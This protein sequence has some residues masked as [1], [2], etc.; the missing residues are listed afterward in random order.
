MTLIDT[1]S[2]IYLPEFDAGR[3]DMMERAH[4]AGISKILMPAIDSAT[5]EAMLLLEE[6]DPDCLAMMGLHP[7]SVK[8]NYKDELK[9][10]KDHFE[11]RTFKAVGEI[12]LDF[13]WDTSFAKEQY[14]AFHEQLEWALHF[15]IPVSIHSRNATDECIQVVAEH[16]KGKLKG[17]FHC[18]SGNNEQ[19]QKIVDLGLYLG[20]GGVV[21]FK[22]SGLDKVMEHV[23]LDH[24]VLETDA[25][26]LAPVPFRGK[27]N[28]PAYLSY[29]VSKL[30]EIKKIYPD[31]LASITTAN[32]EKIFYLS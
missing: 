10:A 11:K 1:H 14:A 9:I 28:E 31:E 25:P 8:E 17:V 24:V 16:Q 12:G 19:A 2:H 7:C 21:T 22:N 20:I 5:H 15:D 3:L 30:S 26:Y 23:T 18:F 32:A 29:V 4:R 27:R 13:Y 6:K